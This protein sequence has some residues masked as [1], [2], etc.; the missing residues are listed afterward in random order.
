M[1]NTKTK[2]NQ[3]MGDRLIES[4]LEGKQDKIRKKDWNSTRQEERN[5]GR[6]RERDTETVGDGKREI[7]T[8]GY[9]DGK[10]DGKRDRKRLRKIKR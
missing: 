7:E 1:W 2:V 9:G 6:E 3:L 5:S 10:R 8:V 4:V